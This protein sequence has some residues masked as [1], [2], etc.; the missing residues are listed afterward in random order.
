MSMPEATMDKDRDPFTR[1]NNIRTPRQV[2]PAKPETETP[3]VQVR[4]DQPLRLR[5]ART[6]ARHHARA[7]LAT[8]FLAHL[9]VLGQALSFDDAQALPVFLIEGFCVRTVR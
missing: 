8:D 9:K 7:Y 6:N 2:S 5:V 4:S 1:Q 3:S